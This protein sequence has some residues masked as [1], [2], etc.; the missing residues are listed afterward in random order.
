MG[1]GEGARVEGFEL[2]VWARLDGGEVLF[3]YEDAWWGVSLLIL[4]LGIL[5]QLYVIFLGC[6]NLPLPMMATPI[7]SLLA[8]SFRVSSTRRLQVRISRLNGKLVESFSGSI[9]VCRGL[10]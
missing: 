10:A 8:I 6:L 3:F 9:F 7:A 5:D 2:E 4:F 1:G